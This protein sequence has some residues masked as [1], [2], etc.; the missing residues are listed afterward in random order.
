MGLFGRKADKEEKKPDSNSYTLLD[1]DSRP[2]GKGIRKEAPDGRTLFISLSEGD[3][4]QLSRI[5]ILQAVPQDK[6]Q[7][8]QMVRFIGSRERIIA[9]EP[10]R[11]SGS[12]MR[13]NFRVPVAF[14]SFVYPQGRRRAPL[15]SVDLSCGGIAFR[16]PISLAVGEQFELVIPL[17][18][19]GPLLLQ[20]EAL[21]VHLDPAGNF[22][23]CKFVDTIDDQEAMLREAVFAIQVS[24]RA[25]GA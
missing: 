15:R 1:S 24:S 5:G 21:R 23:A 12:A 6:S 4:A 16:S 20:A 19:D 25:K 13:K 8:P 7:P 14:D 22:F 17:T 10:M 3:P 9:L 11:D 2:R 18:S